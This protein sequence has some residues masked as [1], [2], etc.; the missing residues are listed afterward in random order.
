M[1]YLPVKRPPTLS[2]VR[3]AAPHIWIGDGLDEDGGVSIEKTRRA[4]AERGHC[5][6]SAT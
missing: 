4:E 5:Q 1:E 3:F 2:F 6:G